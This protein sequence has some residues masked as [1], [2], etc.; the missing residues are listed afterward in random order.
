MNNVR[1]FKMKNLGGFVARMEIIWNLGDNMGN[2]S[3]GTYKPTGYQDVCV[4]AERTIDLNDN[5]NIPNGA[6]VR[7]KAEVVLGIDRVG[8]EMFIYDNSCSGIAEYEV[9]GTTLIN[10]LK[11]KSY[12]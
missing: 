12:R 1:F 3:S 6:A 8:D 2:E 9:S 4:G 5:T 10:K 7:L 11:L